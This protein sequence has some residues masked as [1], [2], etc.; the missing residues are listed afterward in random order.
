MSTTP[1]TPPPGSEL[2]ADR[3]IG[4]AIFFVLG[5]TLAIFGIRGTSTPPGFHPERGFAAPPATSGERL[6]VPHAIPGEGAEW[7]AAPDGA[8]SGPPAEEVTEEADSAVPPAAFSRGGGG[9]PEPARLPLPGAIR[10]APGRSPP[11]PLPRL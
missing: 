8:I 4:P 7:V 1:R 6:P 5:V 2:P 3:L 9:D 11:L 10:G